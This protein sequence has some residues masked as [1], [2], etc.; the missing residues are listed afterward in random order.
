MSFADVNGQHIYF[1][2]VNGPLA[3][4]LRE[5]AEVGQG[6]GGTSPLMR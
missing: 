2:A 5:H 1:D 6:S 4:F 3:A